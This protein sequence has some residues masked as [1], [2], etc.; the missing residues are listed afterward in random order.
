MLS[1]YQ[2]MNI[3]GPS[4]EREWS[5]IAKKLWWS[6]YPII[7]RPSVRPPVRPNHTVTNMKCH[8]FW[9]D[10]ELATWYCTSM[11]WSID[12]CQ[13]RVSLTSFIWSHRGLRCRPIEVAVFFF[14]VIPWQVTSFHLIAGLIPSGSLCKGYKF[15]V[16]SK[17][18]VY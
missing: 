5:A 2:L 4:R 16:W 7:Y 12:S 18:S 17:F 11:L 15:I 3:S 14:H 9:L 1:W 6:I 10:W 8:T 13:S